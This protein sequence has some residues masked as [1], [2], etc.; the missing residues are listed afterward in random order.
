MARRQT[1]S[2]GFS[3]IAGATLLS[4]GLLLLIAN[5][6]EVAAPFSSPYASGTRSLSAALEL[7][8]AALRATQAYFFDPS[9][10]QSGLQQILI[11]FWPLIPVIVGALMLQ[12]AFKGRFAALVRSERSS[13]GEAVHE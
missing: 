6:D 10:F 5:L 4:V 8:V 13:E 7:G 12:V 11:S 1:T 9:R 3:A 2:K